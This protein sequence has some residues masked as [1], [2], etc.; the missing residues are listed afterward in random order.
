MD[1]KTCRGCDAP[2]IWTVTT[3]GRKMPVDADPSDAGTFVLVEEGDDSPIAVF[4]TKAQ[5]PTWRDRHDGMLYTPHH[6]TC[7]QAATFR[8]KRGHMLVPLV[9][10]VVVS[11]FWLTMGLVLG[12]KIA[13]GAPEQD[14]VRIDES[15]RLELGV[16]VVGLDRAIEVMDSVNAIVNDYFD[17][18]DT[19]RRRGR[20]DVA[21][22]VA[23]R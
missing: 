9:V 23:G 7:P 8:G 13:R 5:E 14:V 11:L 6:S 19:I 21:P 15:M 4:H 17:T 12:G 2:I 22:V 16:C 3:N 18:Q 1:T 20:L 10:F